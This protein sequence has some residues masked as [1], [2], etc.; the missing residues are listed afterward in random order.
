MLTLFLTL[1]AVLAASVPAEAA[2]KITVHGA[3]HTITA[4]STVVDLWQHIER[5]LQEAVRSPEPLSASSIDPIYQQ[6]Q[7]Q[8][9]TDWEPWPKLSFA[10]AGGP[11]AASLHPARSHK[12][13]LPT[14]ILSAS[15]KLLMD[16]TDLQLRVATG[17]EPARFLIA[18][19]FGGLGA[20]MPC[21]VYCTH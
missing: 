21:C 6:L 12:D 11:P 9:S 13:V 5:Q 10:A 4:D 3:P 7:L 15:S 14:E 2:V 17:A 1:D 20:H 16:Y 8:L 18:H 19:T